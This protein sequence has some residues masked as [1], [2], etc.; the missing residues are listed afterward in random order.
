MKREIKFGEYSMWV[1]KKYDYDWY[2]WCV[3][4]VGD[5][6]VLSDI[7]SVE[8]TLHP[9]FPDP[10]RLIKNRSDCF[11]LHSSGWGGFSV[12]IKITFADG[13]TGE[14]SYFLKLGGNTWPKGT[15]P[16][17]FADKDEE[18]IYRALIHEKS[19]W[20]KMSTILSKTGLP[21]PRVLD[22]LRGLEKNNTVR[23]ANFKSIDNQDMWG[24]TAVV[25][26]APRPS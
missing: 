9:S 19:R 12:G 1:K 14:T 16:A 10:V 4:V 7:E 22:L 20:R 2:D 3:F 25:G 23:K 5:D 11:V 21:Q 15:A 24:A 8:Y 6:E 17:A 18:S 13:S 26:L